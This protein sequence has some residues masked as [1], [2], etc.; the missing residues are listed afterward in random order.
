MSCGRQ[1]V[2]ILWLAFLADPLCADI[3]L[4]PGGLFPKANVSA[5]AGPAFGGGGSDFK[6]AEFLTSTAGSITADKTGN[7]ATHGYTVNTG[8]FP[9]PVFIENDYS[10]FTRTSTS[11]TGPPRKASSI[12]P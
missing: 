2:V 8:T 3:I 10:S 12:L 11:A 7:T 5:L 1:I 6:M 9:G 4:V